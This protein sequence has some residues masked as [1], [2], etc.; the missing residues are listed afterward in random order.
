MA[1]AT[2]TINVP[3]KITTSADA[4]KLRQVVLPIGTTALK[5]SSPSAFYLQL[6]GAS[7]D[8]G[9]E[10]ATLQF[11][12][13]AGVFMEPLWTC[14]EVYPNPLDAPLNIYFIGAGTAQA[15]YL[16]AVTR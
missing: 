13:P 10:D 14:G 5:M 15:I 9:A 3:K 12:Y 1:T 7:A 2:L 16:H 11:Y 4:N 6:T 8:E